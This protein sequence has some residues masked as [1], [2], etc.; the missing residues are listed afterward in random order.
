MANNQKEL[1]K[2]VLDFYGSFAVNQN[3]EGFFQDQNYLS[4]KLSFFKEAAKA[5]DVGKGDYGLAMVAIVL[6]EM[7]MANNNGMDFAR[8]F[9]SKHQ[10]EPDEET[11]IRAYLDFLDSERDE[12]N[13]VEELLRDT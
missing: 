5:E 6:S 4:Q 13:M 3:G 7:K 11:E 2:K 1:L 8:D 9:M 10:L 12:G